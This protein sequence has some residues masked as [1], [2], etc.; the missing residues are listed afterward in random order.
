[1]RY[2]CKEKDFVLQTAK[3]NVPVAPRDE[4]A[5]VKDNA[6]TGLLS[7]ATRPVLG[8]YHSIIEQ[9]LGAIASLAPQ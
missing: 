4:L 3:C 9:T 6:W 5:E 1:M 7:F 8:S 2:M